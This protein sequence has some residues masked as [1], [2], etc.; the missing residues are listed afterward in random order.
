MPIFAPTSFRKSSTK[1]SRR[2]APTVVLGPARISCARIAP[3]SPNMPAFTGS[4]P[5][6][7]TSPPLDAAANPASALRRRNENDEFARSFPGTRSG[8]VDRRSRAAADRAAGGPGR[9][10]RGR[11]VFSTAPSATNT[12]AWPIAARLTSS[13]AGVQPRFWWERNRWRLTRLIA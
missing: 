9:R 6:F 13:S 4:S 5:D 7:P 11:G 3:V 2:F 8:S 1:R 10:L 12:P